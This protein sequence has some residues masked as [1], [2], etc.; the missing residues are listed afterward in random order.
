MAEGRFR[1]LERDPRK[2][3]EQEADRQPDQPTL[4]S[5]P[6][7]ARRALERDEDLDLDESG[8]LRTHFCRQCDAENRG[9]REVCYNCGAALDGPDQEAFDRLRRGERASQREDQSRARTRVAAVEEAR[10]RVAAERRTEL[11]QERESRAKRQPELLTVRDP[12]LALAVVLTCLFAT[13]AATVHLFLSALYSDHVDWSVLAE[14]AIVSIVT[15]I[16]F[17]VIRTRT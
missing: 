3:P 14:V 10:S 5:S 13:V 7:V 6:P 15:W 8:G 9:G 17:T 11:E 16:T 4:R 1:H 2:R 12:R